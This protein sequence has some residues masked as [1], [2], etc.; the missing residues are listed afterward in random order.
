VAF[1]GRNAFAA[2]NLFDHQLNKIKEVFRYDT[3]AVQDGKIDLFHQD[4][5]FTTYKNKL[6]IATMKGLSIDVLD[7]TGKHLYTIK[8]QKEYKKRKF[9]HADEKEFREYL[10]LKAGQDYE[11]ARERLIFP[12][13]YPEIAAFVVTGNH[14]FV[15]TWKRKAGQSEFLIFDIKGKLVKRAYFPFVLQD[16]VGGYPW[17]IKNGKL[18]Q[19]IKNRDTRKWELHGKHLQCGKNHEHTQRR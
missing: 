16:P 7:H 3:P 9:T 12:D 14:V 4:A 5:L 2:V 19:L 15:M 11:A 13:Y 1:A 17:N 10:K 8:Y 6:F 18:Y